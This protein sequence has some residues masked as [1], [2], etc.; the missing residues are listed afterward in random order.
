MSRGRASTNQTIFAGEGLDWSQ[1][2]AHNQSSIFFCKMVI[3]ERLPERVACVTSVSSRGSSRK[4]GQEQKKTVQ[5]FFASA[6]T[7]AQ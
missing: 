1:A 2:G 6:L 4:L 3:I 5:P 7:F